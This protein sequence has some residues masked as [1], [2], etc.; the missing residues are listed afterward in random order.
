M[1]SVYHKR[2]TASHAVMILL[3]DM[4]YSV[5]FF[6]CLILFCCSKT[7]AS[8]QTEEQKVEALLIDAV[9]TPFPLNNKL[10]RVVSLSPH[11]TDEIFLLGVQ[12]ILVG[13]TIHCNIPKKLKGK[14]KIVGDMLQ[15]S[16]EEIIKLDPSLV[17]MSKEGNSLETR[18]HLV[19]LGIK[20][21]AFGQVQ[22]VSDI[23]NQF[24]T[25]GK[26]VNKEDEAKRMINEIKKEIDEIKRRAKNAKRK[27]VFIQLSQN[28]IISVSSGS[29]LDEMI[30]IAGGENIARNLPQRYP[31]INIE[32]VIEQNP[33]VIFVVGDMDGEYVKTMTE[34]WGKYK[35]IRAVQNRRIYSIHADDICRPTPTCFI[36]GLRKIV[37]L[38]N[39]EN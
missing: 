35:S 4:K 16:I 8:K 15:P 24:I 30:E 22:N 3:Q 13:A 21:F 19:K 31:I 11:I 38:L 32:V 14:V 27:K 29:F 33:D 2:S 28:P 12:D 20:V 9:G 1:D 17:F 10:E 36:G 26:L 23:F 34:Y 39:S 6:S 5:I 7:P 25:L 18:N 37:Q